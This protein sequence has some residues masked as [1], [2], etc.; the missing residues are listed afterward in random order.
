MSSET[1]DASL[2]HNFRKQSCHEVKSLLSRS[3]FTAI[4]CSCSSHQSSC[5][6]QLTAHY[7]QKTFESENMIFEGFIFDSLH[8]EI[9]FNGGFVSRVQSFMNKYF[10]IR[11]LPCWI[12]GCQFGF[13]VR[14]KNMDGFADGFFTKEF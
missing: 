5:T 1:V 10:V 14:G 7:L 3:S 13:L 8:E 4:D 6:K 9:L 12:A 2:S 11:F